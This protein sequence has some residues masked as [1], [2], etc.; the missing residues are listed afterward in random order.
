VKIQTKRVYDEPSPDDGTR[1]LAD[2]LWPRG[3]TKDQVRAQLWAK[4]VA[5]STELRQ[6]YGHDPERFDDFEARYR[7]ELDTPEGQA[8]LHEI[9]DVVEPGIPLTLLTSV[10][11]VDISHLVVLTKVLSALR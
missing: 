9:L 3:L 5:P 10:K 2:R 4:H 7:A 11:A 8:A 1:V 6:W